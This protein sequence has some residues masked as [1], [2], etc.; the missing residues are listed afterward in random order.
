MQIVEQDLNKKVDK[1]TK[2]WISFMRIGGLSGCH[3]RYDRSF[4]F[5]GFQFPVCARCTGIYLGHIAAILLFI[6][7]VKISIKVCILLVLIMV[8]DGTVQ[9]LKIKKS[10]NIRRLVTG[11]FA[12]IGL[13]YLLKEVVLLFF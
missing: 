13:I 3:Q 6:L 2:I 8:L 5:F 1:K 4:T 12:G 11:F 7:K 9:L 10:T